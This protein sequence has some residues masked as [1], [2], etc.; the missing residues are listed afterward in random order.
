LLGARLTL[1]GVRSEITQIIVGLFLAVR[2]NAT[3]ASPAAQLQS[4]LNE[5]PAELPHELDR[6]LTRSSSVLDSRFAR[7]SPGSIDATDGWLMSCESGYPTEN[8]DLYSPSV[9]A[10]VTAQSISHED[11]ID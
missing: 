1:V 4:L 3:H 6:F 5:R 10:Q 8:G 9:G 7:L 2:Q 11:E